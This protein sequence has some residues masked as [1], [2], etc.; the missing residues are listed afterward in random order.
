M[1]GIA[2]SS[3]ARY[4]VAAVALRMPGWLYLA[5]LLRVPEAVSPGAPSRSSLIDAVVSTP[6]QGESSPR[7]HR[8]LAVDGTDAFDVMSRIGCGGRG[9]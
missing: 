1:I 7:L 2:G 4:P 6:R 9:A 5:L 3:R 8:S